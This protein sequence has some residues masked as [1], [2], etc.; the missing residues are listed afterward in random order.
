MFEL[1]EV[2]VKEINNSFMKCQC[3]KKR[4][5][6]VW[7]CGHS[8]P[9]QAPATE[10]RQTTKKSCY[11]GTMPGVPF[12][13]NEVWQSKR[14]DAQYSCRCNGGTGPDGKLRTECRKLDTN[15][16]TTDTSQPQP[17]CVDRK[18]GAVYQFKSTWMASDGKRECSCLIDIQG[19]PAIDCRI[20]ENIGCVIGGKNVAYKDQVQM[21]T[22]SI[23]KCGPRGDVSCYKPCRK[24]NKNYEPGEI[25]VTKGIDGSQ[26][27]CSCDQQGFW[28]CDLI[29]GDIDSTVGPTNRPKFGFSTTNLDHYQDQISLVKPT[30]AP[31]HYETPATTVASESDYDSDNE[32]DSGY[33][34]YD[35][36]DQ[37]NQNFNKA[38]QGN[39]Q[40][41]HPYTDFGYGDMSGS[42]FNPDQTSE[43]T[44]PVSS[45]G[46]L[47]GNQQRPSNNGPPVDLSQ[48]VVQP[49]PMPERLNKPAWRPIVP[50]SSSVEITPPPLMPV[51]QDSKLP[52]FSQGQVS[53][54]YGQKV[55]NQFSIPHTNEENPRQ[56]LPVKTKVYDYEFNYIDQLSSPIQHPSGAAQA[57]STIEMWNVKNDCPSCRICKFSPCFPGSQCIDVAH[58]PGFECG[59]CP[60]GYVG[61]GIK[62]F[63][64][65]SNEAEEIGCGEKCDM[66]MI[67]QEVIVAPCELDIGSKCGA[68]V[69][70]DD[71]CQPDQICV[72][73]EDGPKCIPRKEERLSTREMAVETQI[74]T[75]TSVSI[76]E[77]AASADE[78]CPPNHCYPGVSC[79]VHESEPKCESCPAGMI[80][81]GKHC[82]RLNCKDKPCYPGSQCD[83][84][85]TAANAFTCG[86][87]PHGLEGDGIQCDPIFIE[88]NAI[89]CSD[90]PC[91]PGVQCIQKPTSVT[92]G[93][94]P[95]GMTGDGVQCSHITCADNPC[96][97]G[98]DCTEPFDLESDLMF[99][100]GRCPHGMNGNGV[101]CQFITC[102]DRP[103]FPGVDCIDI[104][105]NMTDD[106]MDYTGE[107]GDYDVLQLEAGFVCG[108]CPSGFTGNGEHCTRATCEP[109]P[110]WPGVTCYESEIDQTAE[111]GEC[112]LGMKGNGWECE[113]KKCS[114]WS[115]HGSCHN[116]AV[117]PQ[118]E[119]CP[120][121]FEGD[122]ITC[123][124]TRHHCDELNCFGNCTELVDGGHCAPCPA[125]HLGD[126]VTCVDIRTHC[127]DIKCDNG[128]T[129]HEF[130]AICNECPQ[131]HND[132]HL[133]G[134]VCVDLRVYCEEL[135]CYGACTNTTAGGVCDPC[136]HYFEGDGYECFDT[137]T[138]CYEM[139]C[140]RN[141]CLET[142]A[143]GECAPCPV[144][145]MGNG[146][147][148]EEIL[149]TEAITTSTTLLP[150]TTTDMTTST[151]EIEVLDDYLTTTESV[152]TTTRPLTS[153]STTT[154]LTSTTVKITTMSATTTSTTA[155]MS[156]TS[157]TTPKTATMTTTF[158]S[159]TSTTST[160]TSTTTGATT[161][162]TTTTTTATTTTTS[163]T[164]TTSS[165]TTTTTTTTT[166]PTTTT[167]STTRTT[168]ST[169]TT[170]TSTT[171]TWTT[172]TTTTSTTTETTT[173]T[174]ETTTTKVE[175]FES[176]NY[177]EYYD[178]E[179]SYEYD[180]YDTDGYQYTQPLND[181]PNCGDLN[182]YSSCI[183]TNLCEPCPPFYTDVKNDGTECRDDRVWCNELT[184]FG[185]CNESDDG[186]A[187]EP[188][189]SY[190][191]GN[192]TVCLDL[193]PSCDKMTCFIACFDDDELGGICAPCPR[194]YEGDGVDCRDT[195]VHCDELQCGK[196][197]ICKE[198]EDGGLCEQCP[199]GTISN[200]LNC[201]KEDIDYTTCSSQPCYEGVSCYET[202]FGVRCGPCPSGYDGNG[203]YCEKVLHF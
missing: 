158:V 128:C 159:T 3:V 63:H 143:G 167:R 191:V 48:P 9:A 24:L 146:T 160:T 150:A 103:C 171:T 187:C 38:P 195:R 47:E 166:N 22:E 142:D 12:L 106:N 111:C 50:D 200:G 62:C 198:T 137:R 120:V 80:G 140:F 129:E 119:P 2:T 112:P 26:L 132:L 125:F 148:C 75:I 134:S 81:D 135:S 96:F 77:Q 11:D 21:D 164:T 183:G 7:R 79:S 153:L 41:P 94:C 100:C 40:K 116:T 145:F 8:Q 181:Q 194:G 53:P 149:T 172:S 68:T 39:Q 127:D 104:Q 113:A 193:R 130:G 59:S 97:D 33:S 69:C 36:L 67:E 99:E 126:G 23:C 201:T 78:E 55:S 196:K 16:P 71:T 95:A 141:E 35:D 180:E 175:L 1:G 87:C 27:V 19:R 109:N 123:I 84:T 139:N 110:C 46:P 161:S 122:G 156:T 105:A 124:D 174:E 197:E 18:T 188:C 52:Q 168:T 192:G 30:T 203:F 199:M 147:I 101:D 133:N 152:M 144:G 157:I 13:R 118:C 4:G 58:E 93:P 179:E 117:G 89:S 86:P 15:S 178:Y 76:S 91:Y 42:E 65:E 90:D 73:E 54:P 138:H 32:Y 189:P 170:T 163:P 114:E 56:T 64:M 131:Y 14:D 184:C 88:D 136:P 60:Y 29:G 31:S 28:K 115:C 151:F 74:A 176:A 155:S 49:S 202:R 177:S 190:L 107:Y 34:D 186:G 17:Q 83:D 5:E 185:S 169:T 45:Q 92:C 165:T 6:A 72:D 173:T 37:R 182:C 43:I 70:K 85:P 162:S 154:S 121:F 25:T 20:R 10:G 102:R 98:V 108:E 57:A 51:D 82:R 44:R 61:N 66:V